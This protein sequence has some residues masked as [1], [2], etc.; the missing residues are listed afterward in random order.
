MNNSISILKEQINSMMGELPKLRL[1]KDF[2]NYKNIANLL[3][4]AYRD[5]SRIA[6]CQNEGE[7]QEKFKY[8]NMVSTFLSTEIQKAKENT[9]KTMLKG[10]Y[11]EYRNWFNSLS[12]LIRLHQTINDE[13]TYIERVCIV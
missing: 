4:S 6:R 9:D 8:L 5:Y 11:L 13:C 12:I 2:K 10:E 3:D 1:N 7:Q